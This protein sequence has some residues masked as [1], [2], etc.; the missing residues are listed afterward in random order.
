MLRWGLVPLD[1]TERFHKILRL[2]DARRAVP[3]QA[4]LEELGISPATFKRDLEY[5]CDRL[6]API[7]W[8]RKLRGYRLDIPHGAPRFQLPGVWF[9]ADEAHA[10][11]VAHQLLARLEPGLLF[12]YL[13]P[14]K[15]R[16]RALLGADHSLE[17][18]QKRIRILA[19]GSRPVAQRHFEMLSTGVL[20]RRRLRITYESR[21]SGQ[22][23]E[24]E[25]SPQ[26]L[27][28]Y[29]D[30]WYLDAWCH[31][32]NG[33][34]TFALDRIQKPVL[35]DDLAQEVLDE[36]LDREL[37]AG[38]GIFAGTTTRNAMLRF[39]PF[40]ARWVMKERWHPEQ[41]GRLAKD[42]HY[43]LEIP[44]ADDRELVMDVLRYGRDVEVLA[45]EELRKKVR[46]EH[47]A[48]AANYFKSSG[49]RGEPPASV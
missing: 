44:Y 46:A 21:A 36:E 5:L 37:G 49:S 22:L 29:R 26:R 16:I 7:I 8:D 35:L 43:L 40:Q 9:S 39:S 15:L 18:V 17:Q 6:N 42:G 2:L 27:V 41:K 12:P 1:R 31:L 25:I 3:R 38:Y 23:S 32:R 19:L 33:L 30:N 13:E 34:R 11:L 28:H 14:L 47:Q 24:R 4:F 48:A 10:L 45:P 20:Q